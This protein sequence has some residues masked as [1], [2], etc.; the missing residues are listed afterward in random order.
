MFRISLRTLFV[1]V[2]L[3]A[4]G[5][6]VYVRQIRVHR[7]VS[8]LVEKGGTVQYHSPVIP[9]LPALTGNFFLDV[10]SIDL[11][12]TR[13][14]DADLRDIA[15]LTRLERLYLANTSIG[16]KGV[17]AISQVRNLRR[18]ALWQCYN[19][20]AGCIDD[21]LKLE[22]LEVLD[23]HDTRMAANSLPRLLELPSL[24]HL[25]CTAPF[26]SDEEKWLDERDIVA[27]T[28]I[29]TTLVGDCY[30][31][32][33]T[34][35]GL[36]LLRTFDASRVT[37]LILRD[38]QVSGGGMRQL[39]GMSLQQL[40]LQRCSVNDDDLKSIPWSE[41]NRVDLHCDRVT[42]G[43]IADCIGQEC[44][45]LDVS[46]ELF[47]IYRE[48]GGHP[49]DL[50]VRFFPADSRID[51]ATLQRLAG[52]ELLSINRGGYEHFDALM[53]VLESVNPELRL[54]VS[55][56]GT[57][58]QSFWDSIQRMTRLRGLA[59]Y[60]PPPDSLRFT[61]SHDLGSLVIKGRG[62]IVDEAAFQEIA[63]LSQ[64]RFL[65]LENA[66]TITR[67]LRHL[68]HLKHLRT[69]RIQHMSDEAQRFVSE[70]D[71]EHRRMAQE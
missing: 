1:L 11:S 23:I 43:G 46:T 41:I 44:K 22:K 6:A 24:K 60:D 34:D 66:N 71:L 65:W 51:A 14:A 26:A 33:L 53:E 37:R 52:L 5:M 61:E 68:E 9:V 25:L 30:A 7:V 54:S 29:K 50:R 10:E 19:I 16:P 64:L 2:T 40:G 56:Q 39:Q 15:N 48:V 4:I 59:V 49:K 38:C 55:M 47:Q 3:I 35:R 57:G 17:E 12:R 27:L 58:E 20:N 8:A 13:I 31:Y 36:T 67:E 18:L 63:K 62:V 69:L 28:R 32:G 42:L 45:S 70:L 21:L